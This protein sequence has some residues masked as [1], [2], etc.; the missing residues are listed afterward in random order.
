MRKLFFALATML[1][2]AGLVIA[3]DVTAT[4][5]DA[6]KK[7][8]TVKDGDKEVTYKISGKV[9]VTLLVGKDKEMEGKF[10]DLEK[11]LKNI[12]DKG[13]KLTI[14]TKDKEITEVKFRAGGGKKDK[15]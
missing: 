7:E 15:N 12:K 14:E 10:E 11:R 2:M 9:K 8:V 5:Y 1:F 3:A 13:V 4:K 6:D